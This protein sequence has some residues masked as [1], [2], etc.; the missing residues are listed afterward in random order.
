[1]ARSIFQNVEKLPPAHVLVA[2][3]E[4]LDRAPTRYWQLQFEP[5][6]GRSADQWIEAVQ[7]AV[8]E[9]VQLHL[10]A[11]VPV[12]AFLSGGLDS[13]VVV[14]ACAGRTADPLQTFSIGF[15]E[16]AFSEL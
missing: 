7:G 10:V 12:G 14:A 15:N 8:A 1:G 6:E 4:S 2:T 11:D 3:A 5:D 9:A 16:E 13:S